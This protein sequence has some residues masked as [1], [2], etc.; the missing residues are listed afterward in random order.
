MAST[1]SVA[2]AKAYDERRGKTAERGY[3]SKWQKASAGHLRNNPLCRYCELGVW[4]EPPRVTAATLV[5]HF[6]PHRGDYVLFWVSALWVSSCG[7]CH[8]GPKQAL[9]RRGEAALDALGRRL[10]L[11]GKREALAAIA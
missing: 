9:E 11:P 8:S 1:S 3:G 7:P 2:I 6:H 4:G 5:D 10:G